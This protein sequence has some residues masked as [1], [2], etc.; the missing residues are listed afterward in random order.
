MK[1]AIYSRIMEEDQRDD[2]Q[3]F[4]DE[5]TKQKIEPVI[6]KDFCE[7]INGKINLPSSTTTFSL[8]GDLSDEIEFIIK[9]LGFD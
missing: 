1:A 8:S 4:F 9:K 2:V 5:L 7:Q 3:L 6:F